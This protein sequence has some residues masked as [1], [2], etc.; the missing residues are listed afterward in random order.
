MVS[1]ISVYIGDLWVVIS[2]YDGLEHWEMVAENCTITPPA[3]GSGGA[4][5]VLDPD[6]GEIHHMQPHIMEYVP[7]GDED[8]VEVSVDMHGTQ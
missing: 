7:S 8:C 6:T 1:Y 3:P 2:R 4:V 5:E